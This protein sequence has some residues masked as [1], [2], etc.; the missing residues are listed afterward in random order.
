MEEEQNKGKRKRLKHVFRAVVEAG[1]IVFLFYS[2][3]LMGE[4]SH[5]GMGNTKGFMWALQDIFT[6]Q[7]FCIAIVSSLICYLGIEFLRR[8]L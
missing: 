3:L 5:S 8:R 7:N 6:L 1:S 4:Y 2:N